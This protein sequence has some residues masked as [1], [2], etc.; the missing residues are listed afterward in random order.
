MPDA[1]LHG[2]GENCPACALRRENDPWQTECHPCNFCQSTGRVPFTEARIVA[3]AVAWAKD[4]YW[5]H[6]D[7]RCD[8]HNRPPDHA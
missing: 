3:D 7:E 6:F 2:N 4:H 1:T 8:A 5:R